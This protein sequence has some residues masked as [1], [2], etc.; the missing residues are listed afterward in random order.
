MVERP[1][2]DKPEVIKV[3]C[4][5]IGREETVAAASDLVVRRFGEIDC[6]SATVPFAFT[7]Y[8]AEEMGE[9]LVRKWVSFRPLRERA[10]LALA[11]HAAVAL[12]R[13]LS[14]DGRR[15]VNIDPGYVDG[16]QV[17][18]STAKNFSHRIYIGSG[19]YAEVT[20]IYEHKAFKFLEWTYP[21]YRTPEALGFFDEARSAYLNQVRHRLDQ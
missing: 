12:E 18:L 17:V 7:G 10:Y 4:G 8:Y 3:F 15:Q 19:Y 16:A 2:R 5:L 20:L 11:K 14:R 9:H 6:E 13:D 21:D 1:R